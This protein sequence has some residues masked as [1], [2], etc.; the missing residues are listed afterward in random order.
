MN[1]LTVKK[2]AAFGAGLAVWEATVHLSLLLA[3]SEP[4]LFGIHLG[5]RLN[6]VQTIVPALC[7][8]ALLRYAFGGRRAPLA[9]RFI[10]RRVLSGREPA[11]LGRTLAYADREYRTI[12]PI[13]TVTV[14]GGMNVRL[15]AY[16]IALARGMRA[17]GIVE[18]EV[19]R[20]LQNGLFRA[21]LPVW[22]L[23]DRLVAMAHPRDRVARARTRERV[24]RQLY[25]RSPDWRMS[26]VPVDRGFGLDV[27]RCVMADLMHAHGESAL[28]E[29]VLCAQDLRMAAHRGDRLQRTT[30][31]A[32]GGDRCDFRF[33]G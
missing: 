8:A 15:A 19:G 2:V 3:R 25:Y 17:Q 9:F 16:V 11:E 32:S 7:G 21:M 26:D 29:T 1:T 24:A 6:V 13:D 4:R 27:E 33:V 23:P 18:A 20:L 12:T 30:T 5:R 14:A 28:C 10:A 31:L 22:W